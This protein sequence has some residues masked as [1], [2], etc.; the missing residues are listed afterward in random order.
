MYFVITAQMNE[1]NQIL[2]LGQTLIPYLLSMLA[3]NSSYLPTFLEN[4]FWLMV[5]LVLKYQEGYTAVTVGYRN[6]K[7]W[8]PALT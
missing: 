5:S 1:E 6:T 4:F 3:T 7:D 2:L 8:S